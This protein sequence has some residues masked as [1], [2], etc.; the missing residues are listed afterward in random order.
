MYYNIDVYLKHM[1]TAAVGKVSRGNTLSPET[2]I[3]PGQV[4]GAAVPFP[5]SGSPGLGWGCR[6]SAGGKCSSLTGV[7]RFFKDGSHH[8]YRLF[9]P[10]SLKNMF[11]I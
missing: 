3:K 11:E 9:V 7:A 4:S 2:K 8:R 1:I 6:G 5:W 10:L